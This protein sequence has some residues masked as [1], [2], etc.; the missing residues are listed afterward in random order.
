MQKDVFNNASEAPAPEERDS[1]CPW[2]EIMDMTTLCKPNN[3]P[4]SCVCL[5]SLWKQTLWFQVNHSVS[6]SVLVDILSVKHP[7]RSPFIYL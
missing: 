2:W 1:V 5:L 4:G 6:L 3:P 7:P